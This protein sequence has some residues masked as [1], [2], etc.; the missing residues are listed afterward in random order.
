MIAEDKVDTS[1]NSIAGQAEKYL[2][3]VFELL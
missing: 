3:R 2:E 1:T